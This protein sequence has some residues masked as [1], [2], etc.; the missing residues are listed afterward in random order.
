[1]K[2][3]AEG[4]RDDRALVREALRRADRDPDSD[5]HRLLAAVPRIMAEARRRLQKEETPLAAVVP[6]AW[7]VIPR[8][9]AAALLLALVS[10][11]LFVRDAVPRESDRDDLDKALLIGTDAQ[12]VED[13]ILGTVIT[14]EDGNG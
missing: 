13:L 1:M 5:I 4:P 10:A 12:G 14:Q 6:L 9:A 3:N 11:A 8:F 2:K 7:K